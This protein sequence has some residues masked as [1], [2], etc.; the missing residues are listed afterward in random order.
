MKRSV[1]G[2]NWTAVPIGQDKQTD[3]KI[4]ATD[5]NY[6]TYDEEAHIWLSTDGLTWDE[7]SS[8]NFKRLNADKEWVAYYVLPAPPVR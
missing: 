5:S 7:A 6:Y 4:A 2:T 8:L 3:L 1:D